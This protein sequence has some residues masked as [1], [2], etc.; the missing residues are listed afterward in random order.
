LAVASDD[1]LYILDASRG[2]PPEEI[3]YVRGL[4]HRLLGGQRFDEAIT[5]LE[6]VCQELPA[7]HP[8]WQELGMAFFE[9]GTSR[10]TASSE[11]QDAEQK[12]QLLEDAIADA[13][14]AVHLQ[15]VYWYPS[16][17]L[18]VWQ[19]KKGDNEEA[20]NTL[21]ESLRKFPHVNYL[22]AVR[23]EIHH[24]HG[25]LERARADIHE[26]LQRESQ[27]RNTRN[28]DT[29]SNNLAWRLATCSDPQ[30]R[31]P[32]LAVKL[33]EQAV[34]EEPKR[35]IYWNTLGVAR[36]R[37]GNLEGAIEALSKSA[38]L[39]DGRSSPYDE[40]FLAMAHWQLD[41]RDLAREF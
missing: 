21:R 18:A 37:T 20:I 19:S 16:Y 40:F 28:R 3:A 36:F 30:L 38:D 2:Y 23:A 10:A 35:E 9:R 41:Q 11:E 4:A 31:D 34:D 33:A 39:G 6:P 29:V 12:G 22:Y 14:E 32:E 5:V 25:D 1:G 26:W 7:Q 8:A 15:D 27:E 24:V 13:T 17:Y